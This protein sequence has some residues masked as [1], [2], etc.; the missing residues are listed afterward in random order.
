MNRVHFTVTAAAILLAVAASGASRAK[1][2]VQPRAGLWCVC[3][4]TDDFRAFLRRIAGES[5]VQVFDTPEAMPYDSA[6]N[7]IFFLLPDYNAGRHVVQELSADVARRIKASQSRG[8]RFWV[9]CYLSSTNLSRDVNVC[10]TETYGA[11]P[12]YFNQE[13][14]EWNGDVLQARRSYYLP[15]GIRGSDK[16]FIIKGE[17]HVSDCI[18]VHGVH[19]PGEHRLPAT[20]VSRKGAVVGS[21]VNITQFDPMFMRPYGLWRTFYAS[22]FGRISG[23]DTNIVASAFSATWPDFLSPSGGDDPKVALEKALE[24]HFKSGILNSQDGSKGMSEAILSDDFGYR[25]GLRTDSHLLTGALFATAGVKMNRPEWV[26]L[27]RNLV[28][29]MLAEGVQSPEGFYSWFSPREGR[30]GDEVYSS[31]MGRDA[32]A[33]INMYKATGDVKYLESARRAA[34]AF[35]MWMDGR[36]LNSGHFSN[37]SKGGWKGEGTNDNPVFY[38]EMVSFLLQMGDE[39]Y[40]DAATRTIDR[41][42]ERFPAVAPFHFSDNFTYSRYLV[43]LA[44]AQYATSRDYSGKINEMLDFFDKHTHRMGGIIELPIRLD[45]DDEA[46]VG[47]GDG[48]DH[49]ADILYC[50][51]FVFNATSV[52]VKL[53]PE[54]Q[55]GVNMEKARRVYGNVRRF[56]LA[57]Q[58]K[59]D[60]P[61]FDGAWMR[62]FDMDIGEYYGLNKDKGWGA[63]CIES[64][65]VMGF[66]PAVLL[67]EDDAGSFFYAYEENPFDYQKRLVTVHT[68]DRRDETVRPANDEFVFRDG[69]ALSGAD[70]PLIRRGLDDFSDYLSTSMGVRA[71]K[72]GSEAAAGRVAVALDDAL[73]KREYVVEVAADGIKISAKDGRAA[74]Q[75]LFHLEDVMNL[76]RAP[77]LPFGRER[78]RMRFSPRMTHSGYARDIFPDGHLAQ[79]AHAGFDAILFNISGPDQILKAYGHTNVNALIDAAAAWGLEGLWR[80]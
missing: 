13:Y 74:M 52:L 42:S 59:S 55:K 80:I 73:E 75:A 47:I 71:A 32:L 54:R 8:N 14:V 46:G 27:G 6:T 66:I 41:I 4:G 65:W 17:A 57:A 16:N 11:K 63:Y 24:W 1:Y 35:L 77:Y 19:R 50:N 48:T 31:D 28:D 49:I 68:P 20:V 5:P 25:R 33:M 58:I 34:D 45:D 38:G 15:A 3:G 12:V 22:Q 67:F 9:E 2:Q 37:L 18:G 70:D 51:N 43:M 79:I 56:L 61:R 44:C 7:A 76:R 23:V 21:L 62:A 53:P 72:G 36:G 26:K 60:D 30:A 39:K 78:M 10:G 40:K 64:G 29:F 69:V